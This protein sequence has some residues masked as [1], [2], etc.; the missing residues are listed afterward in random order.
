MQ[1]W[2]K[3]SKRLNSALCSF[4][5]WLSSHMHRFNFS[6]LRCPALS[7]V[8]HNGKHLSAKQGTCSVD[9]MR[10]GVF[11]SSQLFD[12]LCHSFSASWVLFDSN[13]D[14]RTPTR[15]STTDALLMASLLPIVRCN[16]SNTEDGKDSL[17][18]EHTLFED[19]HCPHRFLRICWRSVLPSNWP[20]PSRHRRPDH[21]R[22][23]QYC[24]SPRR[25]SKRLFLIF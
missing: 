21:H 9:N 24:Q 1:S 17:T 22:I 10:T 18:A 19:S 5:P 25:H 7:L 20:T 4:P 16:R 13:V 3:H 6:R 14:S 23:Q 2:L 15:S 12:T 11:P 8:I